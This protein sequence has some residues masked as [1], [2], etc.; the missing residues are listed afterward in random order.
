MHILQ[1]KQAYIAVGFKIFIIILYQYKNAVTKITNWLPRHH[2]EG[3]P[4]SYV[5]L[6]T[7][8]QFGLTL[9]ASTKFC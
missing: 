5:G 9:V 8:I 4:I 7:P 3:L 1:F 2:L 6:S